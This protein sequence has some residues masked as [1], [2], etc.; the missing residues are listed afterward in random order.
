MASKAASRKKRSRRVASRPEAAASGE[1]LGIYG[2]ELEMAARV[3]A[4]CGEIETGGDTYGLWTRGGRPMIMLATG[5]G[6]NATHE[7]AH[8]AQDIDFCRE[9]IERI[10]GRY[11]VQWL[12]TWHSHHRLG[13]PRPSGGDVNQVQSLTRRNGFDRWCEIIVTFEGGGNISRHSRAR[14]GRG[15]RTVASGAIRCSAFLYTNPQQGEKVEVPIRVFPGISPFR[16][17]VLA[18]GALD[19]NQI[20][21]EG[22]CFPH[23]R[24]VYEAFDPTSEAIGQ[25]SQIPE[26][27]I[28]QLEE[29]PEEAQ[30]GI[31]LSTT[32][33]TV[34]V[35]LPIP[36]GRSAR[37]SYARTPPHFIENVQ[38][39]NETNGV[40]EDVTE[41]CLDGRRRVRLRDV[42]AALGPSA[43]GKTIRTRS[44]RALAAAEG[45]EGLDATA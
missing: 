41:A 34:I 22:F 21:E 42:F 3:S 10:E 33:E 24:I 30:E 13:L 17:T 7:S 39:G 44:V 11:G 26:V 20:G 40:L 29:L 6:P 25:A 9:T 31:E 36:Q 1:H 43:R 27:V 32:A 18:A 12:G 4:E 5:P 35:E 2:S 8:F 37:V 14:Q 38:V 15:Q 19:C 45:E 23:E 28:E 16:L